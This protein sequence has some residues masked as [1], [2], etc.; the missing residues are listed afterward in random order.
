MSKL[1][2]LL[3]NIH[4]SMTTEQISSRANAAVNSF[5][6]DS[7][8]IKNLDDLQKLLTGF[9]DHVQRRV[10]RI[11]GELALSPEIFWGPCRRILENEYGSQ[12]AIT[13]ME[14]CRSQIEGGLYGVLIKLAEGM[15]AQYEKNEI[16][17]KVTKFWNDLATNERMTIADEYLAKYGGLLPYDLKAGNAARLRMNLF[18]VLVNHPKMVGKLRTIGR[19]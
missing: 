4:P 13:T 7:Y 14:I 11:N 9:Y 18:N 17:S 10:L 12:W 6:I 3:E 16:T 15:I 5:T 8:Q 2:K 19:F 1:E